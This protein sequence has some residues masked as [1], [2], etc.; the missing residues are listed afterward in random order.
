M[1][2]RSSN[3]ASSPFV[4]SLSNHERGRE[5]SIWPV[6]SE[7]PNPVREGSLLGP[8][9]ALDLSFGAQRLLSGC[10]LLRE[11]RP[12]GSLGVGVAAKRA[13]FVSHQPRLEIVCVSGVERPIGAQQ[14][15]NVER[16]VTPTPGGSRRRSSFHRTN[17][18]GASLI[19]QSHFPVP[20]IPSC[21]L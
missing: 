12:N 1:R 19:P 7:R 10:E 20:S 6:P 11:H 16:H 2:H 9:P 17:G 21:C 5:I 3:W 4:V 14:H 8:R 13:E 15:I 18:V